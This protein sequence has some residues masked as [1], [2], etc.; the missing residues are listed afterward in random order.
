[1]ILERDDVGSG[2]AAQIVTLRDVFRV[3]RTGIYLFVHVF[4]DISATAR[5]QWHFWPIT[6]G[7]EGANYAILT[8]NHT[9][10]RVDLLISDFTL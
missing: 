5:M 6:N 1:M 8:H 4:D 10:S 3:G 9:I 7:T 2:E